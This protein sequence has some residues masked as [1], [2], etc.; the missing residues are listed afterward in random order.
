MLTNVYKYD[1]IKIAKSIFKSPCLNSLSGN[2]ANRFPLK[3]SFFSQ[4]FRSKSQKVKTVLKL[5][6][7]TV[8][9]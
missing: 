9:S 7:G 2:S 1:N 8:L 4:M 5:N 6:F 3:V